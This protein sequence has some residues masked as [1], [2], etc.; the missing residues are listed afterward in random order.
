M[1]ELPQTFVD[2]FIRKPLRERVAHEWRKRPERLEYRICH[3]A[4]ELFPVSL[5]GGT[6]RFD[7]DEM[8]LV[9]RGTETEEMPYSAVE[10]YLNCGLGVLVVSRDGRRFLAETEAGPGR[11]CEV[12]AGSVSSPSPMPQ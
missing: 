7:A 11:P 4:H 9:L 3:R 1:P 12:Y 6:A 8:V 2:H 10:P 5:K